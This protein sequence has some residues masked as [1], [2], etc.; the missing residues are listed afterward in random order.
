MLR[1]LK[2]K[3]LLLAKMTEGLFR[4]YMDANIFSINSNFVKGSLRTEPVN[5]MP[6]TKYGGIDTVTLLTGTTLLGQQG[7]KYV[8]AMLQSS[9]VPVEVQVID[10]YQTD[11]FYNS[12]LRN[13][14]AVHVDAVVDAEAK[15]RS[16]KMSNDLDLY[17]FKCRMQS[18]PGFN[19]RFP[20]V[21]INIIAQNNLGIY[22]DLEYS[23]V[24]G[25]VEAISVGT[26]EKNE[27]YLRKAFDTAVAAGRKRV[28]LIHKKTEWPLTDGSMVKAAKKIHKDYKDC[29]ELELLNVEDCI[30]KLVTHPQEFDCIF[31]SDRYATMIATICAGVCGGANLFSS[32]EM[33]DF[34][35]VF[36]PLQV[37]LSLT[38]YPIL[39]PYGIVNA[40][41]DLFNHLGYADCAKE[42]CGQMVRTMESGIKT[43]EF[44]GKDSGEY[45]ICNI[46]NRLRCQRNMN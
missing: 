19:Y 25:V 14:S 43:K 35:A 2:L 46:I 42:L 21:N 1:S 12:V 39:S 23:P 16:M 33:G 9:K 41:V 32:V 18:F 44:G 5:L 28:T 26:K 24:K 30:G 7:S 13:R 10:P 17:L 34:H 29:L 38:N 20:D 4:H 27:K 8:T 31:S 37:K 36:K 22:S 15:K 11:D 6:A 45:V 3:P 40:I